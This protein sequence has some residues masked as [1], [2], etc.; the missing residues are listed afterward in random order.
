M[1]WRK[2]AQCRDLTPFES[3]D[4]FFGSGG[5]SLEAQRLCVECPVREACLDQA[6]LEERGLPRDFLTG[7]RGG[8]TVSQRLKRRRKETSH[9]VLAGQLVSGVAS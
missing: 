6:D 9:G 8:E 7:F 5:V 3:E 2:A 1:S 4:L